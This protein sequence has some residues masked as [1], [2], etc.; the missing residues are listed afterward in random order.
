MEKIIKRKQQNIPD[1]LNTEALYKLI[2][3]VTNKKEYADKFC[4]VKSSADV[5]K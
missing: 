3:R 4:F 5:M 2:I 1:N